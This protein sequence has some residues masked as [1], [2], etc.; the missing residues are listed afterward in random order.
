MECLGRVGCGYCQVVPL[1]SA[2]SVAVSPGPCPAFSTRAPSS[3]HGRQVLAG[4]RPFVALAPCTPGPLARGDSQDGFAWSLLSLRP[5]VLSVN[6]PARPLRG[7][8][9]WALVSEAPCVPGCPFS[10]RTSL[11]PGSRGGG[12]GLLFSPS[13]LCGGTACPPPSHADPRSLRAGPASRL[14]VHPV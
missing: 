6:V 1:A 3:P 12:G 5:E 2:R 9:G 10:R 7:S 14:R 8:S 4:N 13:H 11:L